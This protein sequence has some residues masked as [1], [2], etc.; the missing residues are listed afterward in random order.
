MTEGLPRRFVDPTFGG[1]A[2][3]VPPVRPGWANADARVLMPQA[4]ALAERQA[5][6][7]SSLET[8]D[9]ELLV[10][11]ILARFGADELAE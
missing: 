9:A 7:L 4:A 6:S 2:V 5:A 11:E 8:A 1:A 3:I 10:A